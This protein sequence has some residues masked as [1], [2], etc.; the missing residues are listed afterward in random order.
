MSINSTL[1][2][3][4]I[5]VDEIV[6][7]TIRHVKNIVEVRHERTKIV[8]LFRQ[9]HDLTVEVVYAYTLPKSQYIRFFTSSRDKLEPAEEELAKSIEYKLNTKSVKFGDNEYL[10]NNGDVVVVR[11]MFVNF[12]IYTGGKIEN[13][14]ICSESKAQA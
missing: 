7:Q 4:S 10:V 8:D 2:L 11:H 9:V 13:E 14:D 5:S 12:E 3:E 1:D 6:F